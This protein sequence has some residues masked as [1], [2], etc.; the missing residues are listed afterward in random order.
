MA[1]SRSVARVRE[2]VHVNGNKLSVPDLN[3]AHHSLELLHMETHRNLSIACYSYLRSNFS[4]L[5]NH[6][7]TA[8]RVLSEMKW[9]QAVRVID[10]DSRHM[11]GHATYGDIHILLSRNNMPND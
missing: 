3:E 2:N 9:S 1:F 11:C 4:A 6:N 5:I 8:G 7:A 10:K